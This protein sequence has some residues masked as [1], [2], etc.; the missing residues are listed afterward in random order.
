MKIKLDKNGIVKTPNTIKKIMNV[1]KYMLLFGTMLYGTYVA[2]ETGKPTIDLP[3]SDQITES[4]ETLGAQD[5][6]VSLGHKGNLYQG[7]WDRENPTNAEKIR[8][9]LDLIEAKILD[10]LHSD[11]KY[12]RVELPADRD[13][14]TIYV[15]KDFSDEQIEQMQIVVDEMNA[16]LQ[17]RVGYKIEL[18]RG[19]P[20][21]KYLDPYRIIVH[22]MDEDFRSRAG[23]VT[24]RKDD[25]I[26]KMAFCHMLLADSDNMSYFQNVFRHECMHAVFGIGDAYTYEGVITDYVEGLMG[27][28]MQTYDLNTAK[29]L[30]ALY[31]TMNS[32]TTAEERLDALTDFM[33]GTYSYQQNIDKYES[34]LN[35]ETYDFDL[36]NKDITLQVD[37]DPFNLLPTLKVNDYYTTYVEIKDGKMRALAKSQSLDTTNAYLLS[38]DTRQTV[39]MSSRVYTKDGH[40]FL[41]KKMLG[42]N[43][44]NGRLVQLNMETK[45]L[46]EYNT[47]VLDTYFDDILNAENIARDEEMEYIAQHG[48]TRFQHDISETIKAQVD[49]DF[50]KS[51]LSTAVTGLGTEIEYSYDY[52]AVY[53]Q[54]NAD[55]LISLNDDVHVCENGVVLI[56]SNKTLLKCGDL[57]ILLR[58]TAELD[59]TLKV[60]SMGVYE[61]TDIS[62]AKHDP[63]TDVYSTFDITMH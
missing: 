29:L 26:N 46:Q 4:I 6:Y 59:G 5:Y 27:A 53:R 1:P 38:S 37:K 33:H 20:L 49:Y 51:H 11:T 47:T 10:I 8:N 52:R 60:T 61:R 3:T 12:T 2:H 39:D 41:D 7:A 19:I 15:D 42:I 22:K 31:N 43:K 63:Y 50:I 36:A 21:L 9:K 40:I 25:N 28:Y 34:I 48:E 24:I 23:G 57:Y 58:F 30:D 32:D 35:D 45:S 54:L 13:T 14:L 56:S 16:F 18:H 44:S 17:S 62:L 55:N